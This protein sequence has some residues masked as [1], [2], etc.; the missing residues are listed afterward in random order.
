V[1]RHHDFEA[2]G[3]DLEQVEVFHTFANSPAADLFNNANAVIGID[4]LVA[5]VE[6]AITIQ[7]EEPPTIGGKAR[8]KCTFILP[9][10]ERKGNLECARYNRQGLA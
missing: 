1:E 7:H 8:N 9:D 10:S 2:A 3:L 4:D 5:Y 6:I